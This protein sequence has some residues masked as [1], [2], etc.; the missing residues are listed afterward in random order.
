MKIK[1]IITILVL[2]LW[3]INQVSANKYWIDVPEN[4]THYEYLIWAWECSLEVYG[5]KV[6]YINILLIKRGLTPLY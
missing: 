2:F 1:I 3:G 5:C 4:I 6:A